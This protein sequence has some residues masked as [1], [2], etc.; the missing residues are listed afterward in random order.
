MKKC[1]AILTVISLTTVFSVNAF[2]LTS[3]ERAKNAAIYGPEQKKLKV[4]GHEFNIKKA[5]ISRFGNNYTVS[6]QISHCLKWRRDDQVY[7][8]ISIQNNKIV[9]VKHSINR[10]GWA[11]LVGIA[12]SLV[13]AY[14]GVPIDAKMVE[15]IHRRLASA[16]EGGWTGAADNIIYFIAS[17]IAAGNILQDGVRFYQDINLGGSSTAV[18]PVGRY[19]LSQLQS[20]FGFRN[21]WASSVLIASGYRVYMYQ[22]DNFGGKKYMLDRNDANSLNFTRFGA[23]DYVSSVIVERK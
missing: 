21:D 15:D 19:T 18:I 10:G 23:N 16:V 11:R 6:G 4:F 20:R 2:A 13:G 22:H 8:T 1:I 14:F 9:D 5:T 7:Y 3:V 17:E 12:G